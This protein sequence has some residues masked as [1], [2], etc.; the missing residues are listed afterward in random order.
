MS[1]A[2]S[3]RTHQITPTILRLV[4]ISQ[5]SLTR[6]LAGDAVQYAR[7]TDNAGDDDD[8]AVRAVAVTNDKHLAYVRYAS[9]QTLHVT[10]IYTITTNQT[11]HTINSMQRLPALPVKYCAVNRSID[12]LLLKVKQLTEQLNS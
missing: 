9:N 7:A 10:R 2:D 11:E 3:E 6:S 5:I 1:V 8:D 12:S 4:A